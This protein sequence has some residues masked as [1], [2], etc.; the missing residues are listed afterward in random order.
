MPC[1]HV[2]DLQSVPPIVLIQTWTLLMQLLSVMD[3]EGG[4]GLEVADRPDV[5]SAV[6]KCNLGAYTLDELKR[7]WSMAKGIIIME[8]KT[9]V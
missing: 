2:H 3:K 7:Y 6:I 1:E 9:D 5:S 4:R 8:T